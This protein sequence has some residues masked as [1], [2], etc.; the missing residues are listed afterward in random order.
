MVVGSFI[1]GLDT[2]EPGIGQRIADAARRYGVDILNA[3]FL[4]PLPGTRLWT[5]MKSENRIAADDFPH[6]WRYY[7]L[8]F[9]TAHYRQF[10]WASILEEMNKCDRSFYSIWQIL[11]RVAQQ[12]LQ[13]RRPVLSLV[14]NLSYRNNARLTR[15]TYGELD[16]HKSDGA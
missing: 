11:R 14:T 10:S 6:D 2:D 15:K 12:F 8:G 1:M 5:Q 16:L 7:T 9:P 13:R 3:L 4:T